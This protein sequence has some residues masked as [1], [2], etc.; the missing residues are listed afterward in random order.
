MEQKADPVLW[1]HM[2]TLRPQQWGARQ[3]VQRQLPPRQQ[4]INLT[5]THTHTHTGKKDE[6]TGGVR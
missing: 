5:D 3:R 6:P 2:I 1:Q 4:L